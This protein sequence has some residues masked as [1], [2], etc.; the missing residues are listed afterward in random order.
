VYHHLRDPWRSR[1]L[2]QFAPAVILLAAVCVYPNHFVTAQIVLDTNFESGSLDLGNSSVD[3][4]NVMLRGVESWTEFPDFYRWVYFRASAVSGIQ[5][6]FQIGQGGTGSDRNEFGGE[7]TGHSFFYSYD[8]QDWF[9]FDNS[10]GGELDYRFSNDA[11]FTSDE[12]FIAYSI[13]YPVSRTVDK[14][15]E[16]A[17]SPFVSPTPSGGTDFVIGSIPNTTPYGPSD[18]DLYG[19]KIT[20]SDAEGLKTK[21]VLTAGDHSSETA[22]NWTL[23][24]MIDFVLSDD[25]RASLLRQNTEFFVYPQLDPLGRLEGFSRGNS[26]NAAN[27]HSLFWN[28]PVTGD[29]GGFVEIDLINAAMAT[30]LNG[31]IDYFVDFHSFYGQTRDATLQDNFAWS[32]STGANSLFIESLLSLEPEMYVFVDNNTT[33]AGWLEFWVKT[34]DGFGAEFSFTAESRPGGE[35]EDYL[36]LGRNYG[37]ALYDGIVVPEPATGVMLML[38]MV[39][40]FA[41]RRVAVSKLIR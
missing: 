36:S 1:H 5:P 14:L 17:S 29:N 7:L 37:L 12:V 4:T 39:V 30:D 35:I 16:W 22:G 11:P 23:E 25:P 38:G 28:A 2:T 26:Q 34:E 21:V 3:G 6:M 33:P 41:S 20:D 31:E 27:D 18:L 19:M 40:M 24:G 10:S 9:K 15:T 13:P 8:Q 32:D